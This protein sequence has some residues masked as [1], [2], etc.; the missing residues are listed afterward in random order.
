[1]Y[2]I[3]DNSYNNL[4][5]DISMISIDSFTS[6]NMNRDVTMNSIVGLDDKSIILLFFSMYL[7]KFLTKKS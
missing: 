6:P 5:K 2:S 1:M 3:K 4:Q 7:N